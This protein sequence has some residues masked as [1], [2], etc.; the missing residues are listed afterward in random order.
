MPEE[1]TR[2]TLEEAMQFCL[3]FYYN[4]PSLSGT[5][6]TFQGVLNYNNNPIDFHVTIH[7]EISV[8]HARLLVSPMIRD[9]QFSGSTSGAFYNIAYELLDKTQTSQTIVDFV[10][11]KMYDGTGRADRWRE[12]IERVPSVTVYHPLYSF[13]TRPALSKYDSYKKFSQTNLGKDLLMS[14]TLLTGVGQGRVFVGKTRTQRNANDDRFTENILTFGGAS[15]LITMELASRLMSQTG[16]RSTLRPRPNTDLENSGWRNE[17]SLYFSANRYAECFLPQDY[18][19]FV[20]PEKLRPIS[21]E[22]EKVVLMYLKEFPELYG[23]QLKFADKE[24]TMLTYKTKI[25]SG[26][27][28]IPIKKP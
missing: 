14:P 15:F 18:N 8:N 4:T 10:V 24:Y 17:S 26:R 3:E 1:I 25:R 12:E 2:D 11:Q 9:L 19:R 5:K 6:T 21:E 13:A 27:S 16:F 23:L 7:E 22:F 28:F 20:N